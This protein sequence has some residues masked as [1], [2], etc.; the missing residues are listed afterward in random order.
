MTTPLVS[1]VI[2]VFNGVAML[3]RC[4]AAIRASDF[5][6][7]EIVVVDDTSTE[8]V[9]LVAESFGARV[10]RLDG[11]PYGPAAARNKG[12]WAADGDLLFFTDADCEVHPD[13]IRHVVETLA[14]PALSAV[15]GSYDDAPA[16]PSFLSQYKNLFHH[17]V[18]QEA[19]RDSNTFWTGCGGIRR[20]VFLALDG[21]DAVRYR[22]PSIEDIDLGVRLRARGGHIRL[23]PDIQ[24]R[25]LK[26]WTFGGLILT[27]IFDRGAPWT[28]LILRTHEVPTDLNLRPTERFSA[29]FAVGGV[30]G[31]LLTPLWWPLGAAGSALLA[32]TIV[33]HRRFYQFFAARRGVSFA[34][35]VIPLHILYYLYSA[36]SVAIGL[37]WFA[38][39][40][41]S[42]SRSRTPLTSGQRARG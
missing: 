17:W 30:L 20:D 21:F 31:L 10:I 14:D 35:R 8:P 9:A 39:E 36:V 12:A 2:P 42:S 16:D 18:H 34:L 7:Y 27:E 22:R 41:L 19:K 6:D 11:G 32:T 29:L 37:G 4:L 40:A 13:T 23:D 24:V 26:R 15:I 33:L 1:V 5:L 3:R 25:H 28:A 38:R